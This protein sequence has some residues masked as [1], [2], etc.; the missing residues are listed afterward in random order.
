MEFWWLDPGAG[1]AATL[2]LPQLPD[3]WEYEGW[4]VIDGTPV[5]TGKFTDVDD[6]DFAD[7]YSSQVASG[8]PFPG[9]DFLL[10]AP[11]GLDFPTDLTGGTIVISIEPMPDNS[12]APFTL[13][14]LV[15]MVPSPAAVHTVYTMDN[16]AAA[17]NPVGSA[18]R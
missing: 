5:T 9:E 12:S 13:K 11:S 18:S 7:P 2:D 6:F 17:T 1:P 3:G 8:P 15:G 16:N 14:P 4:A 10:N